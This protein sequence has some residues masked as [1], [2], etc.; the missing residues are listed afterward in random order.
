MNLPVDEENIIPVNI[1]DGLKQNEIWEI[2]DKI[3]EN[4]DAGDEIYFDMTHSFR[5]LPMLAITVLNYSRVIKK[6]INQGAAGKR[7][8]S[9]CREEFPAKLKFGEYI[10][11][12][13]KHWDL[14]IMSKRNL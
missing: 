13:S 2:F 6:K 8:N 5:F 11:V 1:P 3:V 4:I 12:R 14:H 10:T 9:E 7:D